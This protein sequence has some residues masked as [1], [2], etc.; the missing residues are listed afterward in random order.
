M[1]SDS[2]REKTVAHDTRT[3]SLCIKVVSLEED[4]PPQEEIIYTNRY[5]IDLDNPVPWDIEDD[6][7]LNGTRYTFR[8]SLNVI[9]DEQE[10]YPGERRVYLLLSADVVGSIDP[11]PN[12]VII[13]DVE[14]NSWLD[15]STIYA[16][17]W[18]RVGPLEKDVQH[19]LDFLVQFSP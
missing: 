10:F 2:A 19:Y 7:L 3:L 5:S 16:G 12:G 17:E 1:R 8:T 15:D 4:A 18:L 6:R 13:R 9:R 14:S 11:P